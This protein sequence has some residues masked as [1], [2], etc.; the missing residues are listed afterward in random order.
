MIRK[1]E[2]KELID[3]VAMSV[4]TIIIED[5]FDWMKL[6]LNAESHELKNGI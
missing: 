6:I 3:Q 4:L 2:A 5:Q 1:K